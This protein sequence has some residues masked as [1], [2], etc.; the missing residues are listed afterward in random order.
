M[1]KL[2]KFWRSQ[3][4]RPPQIDQIELNPPTNGSDD[5]KQSLKKHIRA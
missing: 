1:F 5:E 2:S 3:F 4:G